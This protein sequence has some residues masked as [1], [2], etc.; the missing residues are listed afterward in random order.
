M[1]W[2]N[3]ERRSGRFHK[4]LNSTQLG[5]HYEFRAKTSEKQGGIARPVSRLQCR[6]DQSAIRLQ[7]TLRRILHSI[8]WIGIAMALVNRGMNLPAP[9]AGHSPAENAP[10]LA[11][12]WGGAAVA[13]G[14]SIGALCGRL[15]VGAL[16]VAFIAATLV[17]TIRLCL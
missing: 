5:S 14:F 3:E 17:L 2:P 8:L 15:I 11:G 6:N 12:Y 13:L 9:L 7:F 10:W 4:R 16:V 1:V